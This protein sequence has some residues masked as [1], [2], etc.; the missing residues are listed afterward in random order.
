MHFHLHDDNAND[1]NDDEVNV[2]KD[3]EAKVD[4]DDKVNVAPD[5]EVDVVND[6]EVNVA[7]DEDFFEGWTL[8]LRPACSIGWTRHILP[9]QELLTFVTDSHHHH[10]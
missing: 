6:D 2:A 8:S 7:N 1:D 9:H 4:N 5:D 3:G 10:I